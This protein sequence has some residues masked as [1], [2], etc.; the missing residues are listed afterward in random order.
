MLKLSTGDVLDPSATVDVGRLARQGRV[1][2]E[3]PGG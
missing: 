1:S 2:S 3:S